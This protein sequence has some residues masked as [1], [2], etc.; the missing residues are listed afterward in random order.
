[1]IG[2]RKLLFGLW[3]FTLIWAY[4][5]WAPGITEKSREGAMWL[6]SAI[7]TAVIGGNLYVHRQKR[8]A[9]TSGAG[10]LAPLDGPGTSPAA[11]LGTGS[12]A[13]SP[14]Q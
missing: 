14:Y 2:W 6:E 3:A 5:M 10:Q 7:V 4:A 8:K 9:A 13:E 11:N 12:P 1:M